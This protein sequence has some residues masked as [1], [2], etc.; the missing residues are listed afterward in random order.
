M[1][2]NSL[3]DLTRLRF[4]EKVIPEPNSGCWLWTG[5]MA[6]DRYGAI[7]FSGKKRL[8]HRISYALFC[9]EISKD[10]DVCHKC[11][12]PLCVNP[13]HLFLATHAENMQDMHKKNRH[14]YVSH[15][16]SANGRAKITEKDVKYIRESAEDSYVLSLKFDL[17]PDYI[18]QIR[19]GKHWSHV[20]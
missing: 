13:Q 3:N 7:K 19:Q 17:N 16:G 2:K 5:L 6:N 4:M 12:T 9:G 8:A 18:N 15:A 14:K 20:K 11:D 10:L 1:I